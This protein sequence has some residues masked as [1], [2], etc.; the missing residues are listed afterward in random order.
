MGPGTWTP[1]S[2]VFK[3]RTTSHAVVSSLWLEV[4]KQWLAGVWHWGVH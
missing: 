4:I 3:I 1:C 2:R